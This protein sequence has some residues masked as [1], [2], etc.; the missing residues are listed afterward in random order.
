MNR[1]AGIY[2]QPYKVI[3]TLPGAE[4]RFY[5]P[6]VLATVVSSARSFR[7]VSSS[8][9]RQLAN[10]IF[11]GNREKKKM[12]MTAPVHMRLSEQGSSMSFVMSPDIPM[13]RLPAPNQSNIQLEKTAAEY[14][15]AIRFGGYASDDDIRTYSE[16]LAAILQQQ[17]IR[18]EGN[19]RYLG[20]DAP[21]RFFGRRNEV[22][23]TVQWN[24]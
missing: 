18:H 1:M 11:G 20:Y 17:G 3:K 23:V 21:Y 13:Q 14:V 15:A 9:F 10:Y 24:A 5:P 6:A 8:G 19:F 12:A 2:E 7:E 22:I 4:I 16:K